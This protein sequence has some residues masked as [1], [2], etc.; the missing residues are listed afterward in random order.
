MTY[1]CTES[2]KV[3]KISD[4]YV[5]SE[6]P[7]ILN[8]ANKYN[9]KIIKRPKNL[10]KPNSLHQDVLKHSIKFLEKKIFPDYLLILLGNAPII[11]SKWIEECINIIIKNKKISAIVPVIE[12]NDHHPLRAK[13]LKKGFL[14]TYVA[15]RKKFHQ[16]DKI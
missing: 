6:D 9:F 13:K 15:G 8:E 16:I 4:Y 11:K 12:F 14:K 5:S 7:K 10:S 1:P 3:K 2:K